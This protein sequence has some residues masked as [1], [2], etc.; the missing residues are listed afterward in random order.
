MVKRSMALLESLEIERY[1][2]NLD[3]SDGQDPGQERCQRRLC[4]RRG[5]LPS[6][7]HL[8]EVKSPYVLHESNSRGGTL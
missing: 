7:G 5:I 2:I 4:K 6:D 1:R 3:P 8:T